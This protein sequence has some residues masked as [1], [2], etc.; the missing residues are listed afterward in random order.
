M[1]CSHKDGDD[2]G[3][4]NAE[5]LLTLTML[6]KLTSVRLEISD[7]ASDRIVGPALRRPARP[8]P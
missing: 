6:V 4:H 5:L 1:D 2:R 7:S 3:A 8:A